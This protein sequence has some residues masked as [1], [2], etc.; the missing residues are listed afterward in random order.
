MTHSYVE[1]FLDLVIVINII[2][3]IVMASVLPTTLDPAHVPGANTTSLGNAEFTPDNDNT[4]GVVE[5]FSSPSSPVGASSEVNRE[6]RGVQDFELAFLLLYLLE[7]GLKVVAIGAPFFDSGWNQFD[8][9]TVGISALLV[10]IEL[11]FQ[12]ATCGAFGSLFRAA[13]LFRALR[14]RRNFEE[15]L[16]SLLRL[17]P[18]MT[19]FVVTLVAVFYV[20]AIIGMAAFADTVSQCD[21]ACGPEYGNVRRRTCGNATD[22][23]DEGERERERLHSCA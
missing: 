16:L 20:F 17:L 22:V 7:L 3:V 5:P 11:G 23:T 15:I 21:Q 1:K 12:D 6:R 4:L 14:V 13:R 18:K 2:V 10:S 19:R 9:V 8:F